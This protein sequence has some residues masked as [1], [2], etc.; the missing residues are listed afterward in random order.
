VLDI[1]LVPMAVETQ[2]FS[3]GDTARVTVSLRYAVGVNTTVKVFAGPYVHGLFGDDM[4]NTCIGQADLTLTATNDPIE[5]TGTIDFVLLPK[6]LGGVDNGTYGLKVWI[7]GT[8]AVAQQDNVIIVTGNTSGSNDMFSSMM[9]MLMMVM[10][11]GMITPMTQG[12]GGE[13]EE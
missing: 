12:L 7:E 10:M 6:S 3:A 11:M 9:P 13:S 1:V 8:K 4:I 5:A 2:N